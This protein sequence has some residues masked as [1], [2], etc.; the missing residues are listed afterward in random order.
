[1]PGLTKSQFEKLF[2]ESAQD[3]LLVT[4]LSNVTKMQ[5]MLAEKLQTASLLI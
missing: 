3:A 4:Y 5:L 1:V 2:G